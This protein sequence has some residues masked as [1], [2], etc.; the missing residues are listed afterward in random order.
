LICA[1]RKAA[2]GRIPS[3]HG[4][5]NQFF[6]NVKEGDANFTFKSS[7]KQTYETQD[8]DFRHLGITIQTT[9]IVTPVPGTTVPGAGKPVDVQQK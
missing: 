6:G 5:A 8:F 3:C 2:A 1:A 9:R 7:D 4:Y